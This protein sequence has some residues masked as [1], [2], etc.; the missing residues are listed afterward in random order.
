MKKDERSMIMETWTHG[1]KI[2]EHKSSQC[3]GY[4]Q[5]HI[6]SLL[7][8]PVKQLAAITYHII[9]VRIYQTNIK[10][11]QLSYKIG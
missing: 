5:Y 10:I 9:H 1:D 6:T 7:C 11:R 4:L 8:K 2:P 3:S